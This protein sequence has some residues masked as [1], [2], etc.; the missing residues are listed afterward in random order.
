MKIVVLDGH[1]ENPGDLS[2]KGFEDLGDLTV[3]DRTPYEDSD[4]LILDRAKGAEAVITNKT[5]LDRQ[6]LTALAPE[7]K[8]IGVLA[9]GYNV[10]DVKAASDL[11]ITVTNIPSYGT[12]AVAQYTMALLLENV[13][14][15]RPSQPVRQKRRLDRQHRFFLL[16]ASSDRTER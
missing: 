15:G 12:A 16:A 3:Y 9:T 6:T 4:R 13:P 5:P 1:V 10:V 11:G 14:S 7:L 2:W 8:Y